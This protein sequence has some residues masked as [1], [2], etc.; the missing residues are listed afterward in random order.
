MAANEVRRLLQK[1]DCYKITVHDFLIHFMKIAFQYV[2]EA[3]GNKERDSYVN[4]TTI[5]F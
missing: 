2:F 3:V 1:A 5:S 4:T